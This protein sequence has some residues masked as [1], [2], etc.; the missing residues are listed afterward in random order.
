MNCIL[1]QELTEEGLP[2]FILFHNPDDYSTPERYKNIVASELTQEKS[3]RIVFVLHLVDLELCWLH[4][5]CTL[6][7]SIYLLYYVLS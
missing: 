1:L 4:A 5:T 6:G 2:F 3:N 7:I